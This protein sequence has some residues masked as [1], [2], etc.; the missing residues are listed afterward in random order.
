MKYFRLYSESLE[1]DEGY[2]YCEVSPNNLIVRQVNVF[3]KKMYW[4]DA[5]SQGNE[6]YLFTD[7][8][9]FN[10]DDAIEGQEI[11]VEE[12]ENIWTLSKEL[13]Q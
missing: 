10:D 1:G 7:Q 2:L 3:G 11:S 13:C 5:Y 6:S 9:E 12:F 8:P 4:A